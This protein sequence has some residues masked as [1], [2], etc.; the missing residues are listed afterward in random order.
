MS[1]ERVSSDFKVL[2]ILDGYANYA[3]TYL[4]R[5]K[6]R[7][8]IAELITVE[9]EEY[10]V[11]AERLDN[12]L[13]TKYRLEE[14]KKTLLKQLPEIRRRILSTAGRI[15]GYVSAIKRL[16]QRLSLLQGKFTPNMIRVI[17][18]TL[19][20]KLKRY[21]RVSEIRALPEYYRALAVKY[22]EDRIKELLEKARLERERLTTLRGMY[23]NMVRRL[24]EI[25]TT[26]RKLD[27][28]IRELEDRLKEI[29]P[30]LEKKK[31]V[32]VSPVREIELC[33][34]V[35]LE[36]NEGHDVP[37]VAEMH[38]CTKVPSRYF[39]SLDEL[40]EAF[41][42]CARYTL[43]CH[44]GGNVQ[45]SSIVL[46]EG[47]RKLY[48]PRPDTPEFP[49]ISFHGEYATPRRTRFYTG[50]AECLAH[51]P[52]SDMCSPMYQLNVHEKFREGGLRRWFKIGW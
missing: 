47:V 44:A 37:L 45:I 15:G 2:G 7:Y 40:E 13:L 24:R 33:A 8:E 22:T 4:V 42:L 27:E 5:Q 29:G 17:Q 36:T 20:E 38:F 34:T 23:Q 26:L 51:E 31:R 52:F 9:A 14:E 6:G 46:K 16:R 18:R 28:E 49:A 11:L 50:E 48:P 12:L 3:G 19:S 1:Y 35:S 10:R 25:E 21:I 32:L 39:R 30:R 43:W 41:A